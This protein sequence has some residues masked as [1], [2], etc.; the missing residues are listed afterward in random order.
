MD[1]YL[2]ET[3]LITNDFQEKSEESTRKISFSFQVSSEE[4]HHITTLLYN[5]TFTVRVPSKHLHF[6]AKISQY[7]TS[8]TN[9]YIE[10]QIGIFHLE[11]REQEE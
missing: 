10:N 8:I 4:Y 1:V 3:K 6:Q 5:E 2:D 7:S 9:L 11:L